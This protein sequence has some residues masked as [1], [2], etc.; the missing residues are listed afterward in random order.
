[1]GSTSEEYLPFF[2]RPAHLR[3]LNCHKEPELSLHNSIIPDQSHINKVRDALWNRPD[4]GA[5]VMVGSG[6]SR[7]AAKTR[8]DAGDPPLWIDIAKDIAKELYPRS[9]S[10]GVMGA[11]DGAILADNALRLAT[12]L[13]RCGAMRVYV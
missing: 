1:M 12:T 8:P 13:R 6:F 9:N 5:T 10:A 11:G 7:N 3:S 4:S 2:L